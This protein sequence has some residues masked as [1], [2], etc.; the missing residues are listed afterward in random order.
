M[1]SC[2]HLEESGAAQGAVDV[3][4]AVRAGDAVLGQRDDGTAFRAG[5]VQE[6]GQCPVQVGGGS[7]GA[8]IVGAEALEV[9]VEVREVAERQVGM[10]GAHEVAGRVD[11]PLAGDQVRTGAPEV[12]EGEGAEFPGEFVVQLRGPGVAVGFLAAVGVVDGAG[13]TV[14]SV[15]APMAYHQQTLATV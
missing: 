4:G 2:V 7:Q 15:S 11:D 13:V 10:A 1:P 8:R 6:R 3:D 14:K 12:E 5:V 9:V